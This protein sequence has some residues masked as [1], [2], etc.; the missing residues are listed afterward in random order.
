MQAHCKRHHVRFVPSLASF[1]HM[2]RILVLPRY[3]HLGEMPG[4]RDLPGG[5][6]LCP[7]D[8]GSIRLVEDLFHE[9]VPLFEAEDFNVC[10]DEPWELGQGRSRRRAATRGKGA[11]YLEFML[12]IR[13]LCLR[14]GKRM[15]MWGD[16]VLQH[17]EIIPQ[18]PR[19]IVM[20][21]WD[22]N[23]DGKRIPRSREFTAAGLPLVCCPGTHGWQSHG[24]RLQMALANVSVFARVAQQ[25][26]AEGFLN[27]DWGDCGHRNTLGVSL[28]SFAHGAA[29]AWNTTAVDD[30]AHVRNFAF[31]VFGDRTGRLARSL[32]T[33]GASESDYWAYHALVESLKKPLT[34]VKGLARGRAAMDNVKLDS[35]RIG[36]RVAALDAL[37]WPEPASQPGAFEA[38]ALREYALAAEMDALAW[39]RLDLARRVRQNTGLSAAELKTHAA[40]LRAMS[41]D[42][43][44]LWNR[45]NRPSRLKD[46]LA[47]F[48]ADARE[49]EALAR[50]A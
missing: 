37:T 25:E 2:E 5:T 14:H 3:T 38:I 15:N 28:C 6:T 36:H 49:A 23:H 31:H 7:G 35:H 20:L 29:H 44:D 19:D 8:P 10:G 16:I 41:A 32:E 24:T 22:Y 18:I 45:R 30:A 21:N 46:N 42:F 39:R 12:K 50:K 27:T 47:G 1:G 9:F 48:E 4:F 40:A 13:D 34:L 17:P 43:A 33:L 11:V 26:G